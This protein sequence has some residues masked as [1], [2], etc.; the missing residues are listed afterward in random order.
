M[1]EQNDG[2]FR[3]ALPWV[4]FISLLFFISYTNRSIF[5]PLLV[6]LEKEFSLDHAQA[7]RLL[8]YLY[9]GFSSSMALSGFLTAW[10]K[11]RLLMS[12]AIMGTGVGLFFMSR[13]ENPEFAWL[14]F[15]LCGF[16]GGFY[17]T[18]AMSVLRGLVSPA[19]WGKAVTAHEMGPPLSFI[20]SPQLAHLVLS[21]NGTTW[22][23]VLLVLAI[24]SVCCG[25]LFILVGRGGHE[26]SAKPSLAGI[27]ALLKS[28]LL[29]VMAWFFALGIAGEFAPY[30][31]LQLHMTSERGL[32]PE[33]ASHLLSITRT[34]APF[35]VLAGG[36]LAGRFHP[37][38]MVRAFLIIHGL[39]LFAMAAPFLPLAV[40]GM[41]VQPLITAC[42]FPAMFIIFAE[43]FKLEHQAML[44]GLAMPLASYIGSGIMPALLG[45]WGNSYGFAYGFMMM[46]IFCVGSLP[47]LRVIKKGRAL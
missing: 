2:S 20:L 12:C 16:S 3:Q 4:L 10:V 44:L 24:V 15:I 35:A 26:K 23:T 18:A 31:V 40:A 41:F 36:F 8:F 5:G 27:G 22:R 19:D 32:S 9:C 47:L 42:V 14:L 39:S 43:G 37:R 38:A 30:S 7:T 25:L 13:L 6:E 33:A 29:W 45:L 46:G 11:P 21:V 34:G 28:P 17:F 1:L